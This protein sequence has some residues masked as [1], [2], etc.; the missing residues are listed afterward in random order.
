MPLSYRLEDYAR[1][2]DRVGEATYLE[3]TRRTDPARIPEVWDHLREV[4][5]A[6][7]PPWVLQILTKDA[8]GVL[9]RGEP[10]LRRLRD[11]GTTITLHLTV[12]GLAGTPWEPL[13]PRE[14]LRG[15]APLIDLIGGPDHVKWRY[16]PIIATVHDVGRFHRLAGEAAELGIRRGVINFIAPPGRYRRVDRRVAPLLP[17]WVD[18][19]PAWLD[20]YGL[21]W[22]QGVALE[23][24]SLAREAGISLACCAES[25]ALAGLVPGLGP[26]A[27]GDH[28]WFVALSGRDLPR[29][30]RRGSRP[31]CGCAA[32]FDL[33]NYGCWSRCY[34]CAYC[35]AG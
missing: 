29:A 13:V 5:D 7:G 12:T 14:G 8:R 27:C 26:A 6:Y 20:R 16:D 31:G 1:Y 34:R 23:L 11:A 18:G 30:P 28:A 25:A 35:Y 24:V 21:A 4:V 22:Q 19:G 9:R 32:Y 2:R 33:G 15:A 10:A 3:M 17:G